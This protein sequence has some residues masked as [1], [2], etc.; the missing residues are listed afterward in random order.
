MK[1]ILSTYLDR[2]AAGW[3]TASEPVSPRLGMGVVIPCYDEPDLSGCLHSLYAATLPEC[4]VEVFVLVNAPVDAQPEALAQNERTEREVRAWAD[5]VNSSRFR[6]LCLNKIL[7]S[8]KYAGVGLARRIGMD[9]MVYRFDAI[10]N[11]K[12]LIISLDADCRVEA[13]YFTEIEKQVYRNPKARS[14]T[15]DFEHPLPAGASDP[16]LRK[17]M[18]QYE[19]YL[20]Y[21]KH[22]LQY[23]GFPYPYYTI[24]SDFA[25]RAETYC[26]AGGMGKYQGGED[27]YF[28]QK[29][30]P[31]GGTVEVNTTKVYPAARL[32]DRVP[33]GTGPSLIKLVN[34]EDEVKWTYAWESF[35]WLRAF[36]SVREQWF[37]QPAERIETLWHEITV[38]GAAFPEAW[39]DYLTENRFAGAIEELGKNCA[40]VAVFAKRFFECFTALRVLQ[41][42]NALQQAFPLQP[43][44]HEVPFLLKE[45]YG[46]ELSEEDAFSLL[47][48]MREYY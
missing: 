30:F 38:D 8:G 28:L 45:M 12:G 10:G 24:G 5:S 20:R 31:L 26:R 22:A 48:K 40:S 11:S 44:A 43:V 18:I 6:V 4:D 41:S 36:L 47:E 1:P 33:F 7:D 9:E 34:R 23:I 27:F 19:L 17:A 13:N 14:A 32:S 3:L 35:R 37:R 46:K 42:L 25:V 29:V 16:A 39:R 2:H 15:F 21:Y